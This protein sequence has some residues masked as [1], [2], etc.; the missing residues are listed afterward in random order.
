MQGTPIAYDD[1]PMAAPAVHS[2]R[3]VRRLWHPDLGR[4]RLPQVR[5]PEFLRRTLAAPRTLQFHLIAFAAILVLPLFV[6]AVT[7]LL[8]FSS[9]ELASNEARLQRMAFDVSASVDR[10]VTSWITVLETLG[11]SELLQEG[12]L[13]AFHARARAALRNSDVH[14]ILLDDDYD[15][16]LNTR[17]PFGTPLPKTADIRSAEIVAKSRKS[18]VSDAFV[19][20]VSGERVVNVEI[21]VMRDD[22]LRY[23]LVITFNV[24]RI[25]EIIAQEQLGTDWNVIVSDRSGGVIAQDPPAALSAEPPS[26]NE[27]GGQGGGV[28]RQ[29]G[30]SDEWV[31]G[32]RWSQ[33]TGWR[34][35]VR[36]PRATLDAPFWRSFYGLALLALLAGLVT[37]GLAT[38]LARRMSRSMSKL[39]I[40]A[41]DLAAGR[42]IEAARQPIAE[43]NVVLDAIR[44]AANVISERTHALQASE[45]QSRDQVEQ[46]KML[47]GELA[48]RNKNVMA[49]LQAIARQISRRSNSL[50]EFQT[51]F[52]SRIG[53]LVRSNDLL[54]G[55]AGAKGQLRELVRRQLAPFIEGEPDRIE[56]LGP[57]LALR[58][59]AVQSLGL[60]FHELATNATKYGALSNST[61]KVVVSWK[62]EGTDGIDLTWREQGGPPV[63]E[64]TGSGFGKVVIERLTGA[65]LNGE[66]E[67]LFHPEGVVWRLTA[68]AVV[69]TVAE[70]LAAR[71]PAAA[72]GA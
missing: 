9:S 59:E 40:A 39:R 15:Q 48:H 38:F 30:D 14:V 26:V 11:T 7:V 36:V 8:W 27:N 25:G 57:D 28:V 51:S 72:V 58:S 60:A 46:I 67:Y 24:A 47:M 52:D 13:E 20:R 34:T 1:I 31:E 2:G 68:P 6:I 3:L 70:D 65:N 45:E 33:V 62:R 49:V 23:I 69:S 53:A 55:S 44:K 50:E 29:T 43:A 17:V 12:R 66:V 54:F 35:S 61:G 56:T 10:D 21:P 64:P 5:Q 41:G 22:A 18:Y 63:T 42:A 71:R 37:V 16:V 19:G 4:G 32:Y